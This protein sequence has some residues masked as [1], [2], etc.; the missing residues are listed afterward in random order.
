MR[1]R[2]GDAGLRLLWTWAEVGV[3]RFAWVLVL[4]GCAADGGDGALE[5]AALF[6]GPPRCAGELCDG[7]FVASTGSDTSPG[8]RKLPKA[9]ITAG[10]KLGA[11][12]GVPV[13]VGEGTYVEDLEIGAPVVLAG[14]AANV[15]VQGS[16]NIRATAHL[17]ELRVASVNPVAVTVAGP[18]HAVLEDL[19]IVAGNATHDG[20]SIGVRIIGSHAAIRR[21][22]VQAGGAGYWSESMDRPGSGSSYGIRVE[23]GGSVDVSDSTVTSGP[24]SGSSIAIEPGPGSVISR[25]SLRTPLGLT[26]V[27]LNLTGDISGIVVSDSSLVAESTSAI[28]GPTCCGIWGNHAAAVRVAELCSIQVAPPLI[29]GSTLLADGNTH[30]GLAAEIRACAL[31]LRNSSIRAPRQVF[32]QSTAIWCRG[33]S[34]CT[35]EGNEISGA[36]NLGSSARVSRNRMVAWAGS[37]RQSP[38]AFGTVLVV[39]GPSVVDNNVIVMAPPG[40][41]R[42]TNLSGLHIAPA[43]GASDIV[44]N[45]IDGYD[46]GLS[47]SALTGVVSNNTIIGRRDPVCTKTPFNPVHN[48]LFNP[49]REIPVTALNISADPQLVGPTDYRLLPTSPNLGA[50]VGLPGSYLDLDG[51]PRRATAPDIGPYES[52][53]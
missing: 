14:D 43:A 17:S 44:F 25:S 4:A 33:S 12:I 45:H 21:S 3:R 41:G 39:G 42:P 47:A 22:V 6:G 28:I 20:L 48:N 50:G 51:R 53:R 37:E 26:S 15:E 18:T 8:T 27:A 30:D 5:A 49:D 11:S 7:V 52:E 9:T 32:G 2:P 19:V 40:G 29:T 24:A 16:V 10:L 36:T 23:R 13:H 46:C 31:T 34:K 1:E 38:T 35:L